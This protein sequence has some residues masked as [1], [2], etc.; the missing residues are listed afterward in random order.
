MVNTRE[1]GS[2]AERFYLYV[3]NYFRFIFASGEHGKVHF[4]RIWNYRNIYPRGIGRQ[5]GSDPPP[6]LDWDFTLG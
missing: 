2:I 6:E 4:V 1:A 5:P 3:E